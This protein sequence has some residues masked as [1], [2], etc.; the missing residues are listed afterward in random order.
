MKVIILKGVLIINTIFALVSL[1][2][3]IYEK[4]IKPLHAY[5]ILH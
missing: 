4:C 1:E 3:V 5:Y 2:Y